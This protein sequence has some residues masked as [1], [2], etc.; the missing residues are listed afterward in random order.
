M[1]KFALTFLLTVLSILMPITICA[2]E[3]SSE[4]R[5]QLYSLCSLN[6]AEKCFD[7][8]RMWAEGSGG[9]EDKKKA[10]EYYDRACNLD[11]WNGCVF[12]MDMLS[13]GEGS[14]QD[15]EKVYPILVRECGRKRPEACHLLGALSAAA[16][17]MVKARDYYTLACDL[18]YGQGCLM[19]ANLCEK[20][21]GGARDLVKAKSFLEKACSLGKVEACNLPKPSVFLMEVRV[22]LVVFIGLFLFVAYKKLRKKKQQ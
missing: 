11:H 2:Q 22:L 7:L 14:P 17:D 12:F 3:K 9:P 21:E 16:T 6:V 19:S 10:L 5:E 13:K 8:G 15:A 1:N 4:R 20:G 18:G